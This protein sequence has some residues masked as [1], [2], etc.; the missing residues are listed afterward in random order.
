MSKEFKWLFVVDPK[1]SH[2]AFNNSDLE[3]FKN[4]RF[5][6]LAREVIQNSID[7]RRDKTR[8]VR[9]EF[10]TLTKDTSDIPD[11]VGLL[12]KVVAC[13]PT[14]KQDKN[15]KEAEAWFKEAKKILEGKKLDIL[16]M[17]DYNT[18]GIAG[19]CELG[20]P[21]FS[22]MKAMGDSVK[23]DSTAGGSHGIGKRAPLVCSKLRTH[24]TSTR[25]LD[26]QTEKEHFLAQG[27]SVLISHIE[28][29][30]NGK[31]RTIDNEGYWGDTDGLMH[32]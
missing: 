16:Q 23:P 24:I 11:R 2:K 17:S 6:S 1:S 9:V 3:R 15:R 30:G 14:A 13:I 19:P 21:F 18:V 4:N 5:K 22:Y 10:N 25:Y 28:T 20:N 8:P 7:A 31:K 32:V 26:I 27:Y 29:L 12:H